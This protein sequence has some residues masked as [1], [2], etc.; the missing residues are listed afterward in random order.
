MGSL[1]SGQ[2]NGA[3]GTYNLNNCTS[4]N[5]NT[6]IGYNNLQRVT[7]GVSNIG[8][9]V[10]NFTLNIT[11]SNNIGIGNGAGA[12]VTG[13]G[14]MCIGSATGQAD[15]G[16]THN[17][18]TCLG[19]GALMTGSN[20]VVLGTAN[21]TVYIPN[22]LMLAGTNITSVISTAIAS[23]FTTFLGASN[24]F[25]G[26]TNTF[27]A[28]IATSLKIG[29]A[30]LTSS[31]ITYLTNFTSDPQT[32]LNELKS[33]SGQVLKMTVYQPQRMDL[34]TT[35]ISGTTG[36]TILNPFFTCKSKD[37][38]IYIRFDANWG[39]AGAGYDNWRSVITITEVGGSNNNPPETTISL[40]ETKLGGQDNRNCA[41]T[42][43]PIS[44]AFANTSSYSGTYSIK[45]KANATDSN[46]ILTI[47]NTWV[48]TIMEVQN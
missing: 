35:S 30:T 8:V 7:T 38:N 6:A 15:S 24:V 11:G 17:Y 22:V 32:Q 5:L 45:I 46:D 39:I 14:N 10:N 27:G 47:G 9:G 48:C 26:T 2:S 33:Y 20:Q 12:K 36:G 43:F 44:A 25:T 13:S 31:L 34:L 28:V 40:K 42:L 1:T 4:G 18:S 21:E 19:Y 29:T 3:F 16:T 23:A 37:S 41:I